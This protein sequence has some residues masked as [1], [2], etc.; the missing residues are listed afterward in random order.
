MPEH[1]AALT[2]RPFFPGGY[3]RGALLLAAHAATVRN[4]SIGC[5]RAAL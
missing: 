4:A 2:S 1:A 5:I 3:R